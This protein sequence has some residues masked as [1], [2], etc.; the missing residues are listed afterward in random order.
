MLKEEE[1]K[2]MEKEH[3]KRRAAEAK[4]AGRPPVVARVS[5]W[6]HGIWACAVARALLPY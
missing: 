6:H 2:L 5:T 3:E 1:R 4:R